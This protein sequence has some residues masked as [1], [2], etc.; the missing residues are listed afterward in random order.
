LKRRK[1][2]RIMK[3]QSTDTETIGSKIQHEDKNQK[4]TTQKTKKM[5]NTDSTKANEVNPSAGEG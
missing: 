3:G 1:K 2:K 5:G 4:T